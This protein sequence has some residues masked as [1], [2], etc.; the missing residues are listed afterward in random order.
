LKRFTVQEDEFE[1]TK[2]VWLT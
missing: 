1:G 2:V